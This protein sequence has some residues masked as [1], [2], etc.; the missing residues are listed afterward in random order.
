[1]KSTIMTQKIIESTHNEN[2]V[3]GSTNK[4]TEKITEINPESTIVTEKITEAKSMT[5]TQTIVN[6]EKETT[7]KNIMTTE[8]IKTTQLKNTDYY[9]LTEKINE[10]D[11]PETCLECNS[12][13]K[14]TKCNKD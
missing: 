11:C 14:C 2:D 7:I 4:I 10:N 3:I 8:N 6:L 5:S 9:D 1:M 12:E 13:K